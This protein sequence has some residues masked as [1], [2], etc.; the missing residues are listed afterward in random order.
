MIVMLI[1]NIPRT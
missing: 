1:Y